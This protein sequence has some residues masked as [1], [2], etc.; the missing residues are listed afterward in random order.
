MLTLVN[1]ILLVMK[2]KVVQSF[3]VCLSFFFSPFFFSFQKT[4]SYLGKLFLMQIAIFWEEAR[5][6][7]VIYCSSHIR[8]ARVQNK[9]VLKHE[10]VSLYNVTRGLKIFRY[11]LDHTRGCIRHCS[12]H[13]V[14]SDELG[15]EVY[16]H[17][18]LI[19]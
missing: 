6:L 3:L 14:R 18:K 9:P 7:I 4:F 19:F 15:R 11:G 1:L 17:F 8:F 12:Q 13:L 16:A 10:M 2:K 5:E